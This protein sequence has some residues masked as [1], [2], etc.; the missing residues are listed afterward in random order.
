M[1]YS[2]LIPRTRKLVE[3]SSRGSSTTRRSSKTPSASSRREI[4]VPNPTPPQSPAAD[5]SLLSGLKHINLEELPPL[6]ASEATSPSTTS[7][8]LDESRNVSPIQPTASVTTVAPLPSGV[9]IL[10]QATVEDDLSDLQEPLAAVETSFQV[11]E[12]IN[13]EEKRPLRVGSAPEADESGLLPQPRLAAPATRPPLSLGSTSSTPRALSYFSQPPY[14]TGTPGPGGPSYADPPSSEG[15]RGVEH[16]YPPPHPGQYYYQVPYP[17]VNAAQIVPSGSPFGAQALPQYPTVYPLTFP[18]HVASAGPFAM[19]ATVGTHDDRRGPMPPMVGMAAEHSTRQSPLRGPTSPVVH[20]ARALA[21]GNPTSGLDDDP[22]ALIYRVSNTMVTMANLSA[23]L[24]DLQQLLAKYRDTHGQLGITEE[25]LQIR[26]AHQ[27]ETLKQKEQAISSLEGE[28]ENLHSKHTVETSKLRLKLGNLEQKQ[29]ELF[30]SLSSAE[31]AEKTMQESITAMENRNRDADARMQAEK[32]AMHLQ[33]DEWKSNAT[34]SFEAEKQA[35]R[36]DH[37]QKLAQQKAAH[38]ADSIDASNRLSDERDLLR[39]TFAEE[40]KKLESALYEKVKSVEISLQEEKQGRLE[41]RE[42]LLRRF[43]EECETM[44]RSYEEQRDSLTEQQAKLVASLRADLEAKEAET[45][46]LADTIQS[47]KKSSEEDQVAFQLI[48]GEWQ[49]AVEKTRSENE[50]LLKASETF[51]DIDDIKSKGDAFYFDSFSGLCKQIKGLAENHCQLVP[52]APALE[53]VPKLPPGIPDVMADTEAARQ[54]RAAY[55][56]HIVSE[57]LYHRVFQPFLFSLSPRFAEADKL[58]RSMSKDL[59]EK[60]SQKEAV[61]RQHTLYAAYTASTAKKETNTAAGL[62]VEEILDRI[63]LFGG[64][65][66]AEACSAVVRSIVKTAAE[67]WRYARLEKEMFTVSFSN[68]S[69]ADLLPLLP[70]IERETRREASGPVEGFDGDPCVFSSGATLDRNSASIVARLRELGMVG[71]TQT[72][73]RPVS[74]EPATTLGQAFKEDDY[75]N[76]PRVP[77]SLASQSDDSDEGPLQMS[78]GQ[79]QEHRDDEEGQHPSSVIGMDMR[80]CVDVG[81]NGSR[82][83]ISDQDAPALSGMKRAGRADRSFDESR[84][85]QD[86]QET[87]QLGGYELDVKIRLRNQ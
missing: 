56:Q 66:P 34:I 65:K 80:T 78:T 53:L 27:E 35:I 26:E 83:D 77:L 17:N 73:P 28:V 85:A 63:R 5:T 71:I 37:E 19:S 18:G 70:R 25:F 21:T 12:T 13:L 24:P 44:K 3:K 68:R 45:L 36:G 64:A 41:D 33:M 30:E 69:G 16:Y 32:R 15:Y 9:G 52:A 2:S 81:L 38:E 20:N 75:A 43:D 23:A 39:A 72:E 8:R 50:R 7:V 87:S 74:V 62:V 59:R 51:G 4:K 84:D 47:L 54:L 10:H 1:P 31:M 82:E 40:K 29:R 46:E 11:R 42:K 86:V 48:T 14:K 55:L 58:L 76:R 57:T 49:R 67:T 61:W 22:S 6:P 79:L 60:S